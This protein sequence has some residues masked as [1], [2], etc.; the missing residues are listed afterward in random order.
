MQN[1]YAKVRNCRKKG[2]SL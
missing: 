2:E 1:Y